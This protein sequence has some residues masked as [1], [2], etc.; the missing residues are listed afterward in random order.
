MNSAGLAA[1]IHYLTGDDAKAIQHSSAL[2]LLKLKEH[3]RISQ[4]A[5]N[6]IVEGTRA[7]VRLSAER[8]QAAVRA[9]LASNGIDPDTVDGLGR[10]LNE[11]AD[12]FEG[13][14]TCHLQEQYYHDQLGLVVSVFS[15]F[16]WDFIIIIACLCI[17]SY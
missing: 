7:M 1:D 4:V 8:M 16:G 14:Q 17:G 13:I 3:R 11:V 6:D 5:I 2:F 10:A 12:P 15:D 9:N